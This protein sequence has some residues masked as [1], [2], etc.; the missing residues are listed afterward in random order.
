MVRND[1]T[2]GL[3]RYRCRDC[4]RTFNALTGTQLVRLRHRERW[5]GQAQALIDGLSVTKAAVARGTA[6]RWSH[7]LTAHRA[8]V[9][10]PVLAA[11]AVLRTEGSGALAAALHLQAEH[12]A[13]NTSGRP[14]V[15]A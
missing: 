2:R 8:A 3:Q 12:H 9:L 7:R 13:V 1:V 5:P 4:G 10:Q 11:E 6:F 14:R 15:I